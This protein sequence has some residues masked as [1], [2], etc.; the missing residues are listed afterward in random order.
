[1]ERAAKVIADDAVAKEMNDLPDSLKDKVKGG[2]SLTA[3]PIIETQAGDVSAYIPTIVISI[4][5]GQIFLEQDL[6]NQGVR[7]AI[8]VGISVS[9]V[10]GSAQIKSMKKVAGTLKLDQAQF[11]E[12]EAFA[13]FGSD[14]DAATL[15]VI[16]KGRRNVEILKQAQNDPFT[17]EDQVAIIF[18]GSKNLLRDVPVNKVKEFERDFIEFLNAKHRDVLDTLKAGKLTDEVTDTLTSVCK[19][20][21]G[22]Y[23]A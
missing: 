13:K 14:L 23:Q 5:D 6:F 11:R 8:N 18:A 2:G 4:T 10:G 9:R 3:L 7:P 20:L 22:K 21:A 12:L 19:D 15:N 1:M 17:V 16:E